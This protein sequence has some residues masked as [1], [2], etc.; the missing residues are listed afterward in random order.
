MFLFNAKRL[1]RCGTLS[2]HGMLS[3]AQ[4]AP[5][6]VGQEGLSQDVSVLGGFLDELG[7]AVDYESLGKDH[8]AE[9]DRLAS[10]VRDYPDYLIDKLVV[11]TDES[12]VQKSDDAMLW[13]IKDFDNIFI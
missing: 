12:L 10:C 2:T 13:F 7:E 3:D 4:H 5:D 8:V 11:S 9:L 6:D 1:H